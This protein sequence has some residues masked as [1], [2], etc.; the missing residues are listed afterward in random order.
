[1]NFT[2]EPSGVRRHLYLCGF[3]CDVTALEVHTEWVLHAPVS[4]HQ[5]QPS[6]HPTMKAVANWGE[7]TSN[8]NHEAPSVPR[9]SVLNQ[10]LTRFVFGA[11]SLIQSTIHP[12]SQDF[13]FRR[14]AA[15]SKSIFFAWSASVPIF[16]HRPF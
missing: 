3:E 4:D 5:S 13:V 7:I 1:L 11:F 10:K 14:H 16:A 12:E 9:V 15:S 2:S 6:R 8:K